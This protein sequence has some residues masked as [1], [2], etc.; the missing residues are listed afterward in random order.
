MFTVTITSL[1]CSSSTLSSKCGPFCL[2]HQ[3]GD[4]PKAKLEAVATCLKPKDINFII[5]EGSK[6]SDLE[7]E[8]KVEPVNL[9]F[10]L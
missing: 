7:Y 10:W 1:Q 3:D 4:R 5:T 8:W 6:C 2:K 9:A